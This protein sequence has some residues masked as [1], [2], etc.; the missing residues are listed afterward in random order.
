MRRI[1]ISYVTT[2]FLGKEEKPE[3]LTDEVVADRGTNNWDAVE[4]YMNNLGLP[5]RFCLGYQVI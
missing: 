3:I 4:N 5:L 2:E 1:R